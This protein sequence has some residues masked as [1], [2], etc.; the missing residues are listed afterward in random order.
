MTFVQSRCRQMDREHMSQGNA[1]R[2]DG[3]QLSELTNLAVTR[4]ATRGV[5]LHATNGVG[6]GSVVSRSGVVPAEAS[7]WLEPGGY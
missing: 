1:P 7:G 2:Q 5:S 6:P 3:D 4:K